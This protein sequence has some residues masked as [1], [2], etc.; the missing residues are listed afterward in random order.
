MNKRTR[1]RLI[2]V[3]FVILVLV[4]ILIWRASGG[5]NLQFY[6]TVHQVRTQVAKLAGTSIQV[7][8]QVQKGTVRRTAQSL[9]FEISNNGTES[10]AVVYTGTVQPQFKEGANVIIGGVLAPDGTLKGTT[11][12]AKCP[13]KFVAA[14]NKAQAA[15][16]K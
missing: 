9:D 3:T 12:Q 4:G 1:T 5:G 14:Q 10:V 6:K 7:M 8:G 15:G 2:V 16:S 13:S 11:M